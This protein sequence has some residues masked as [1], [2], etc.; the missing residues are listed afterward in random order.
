MNP[1]RDR[2]HRARE[3]RVS[4]ATVAAVRL[5][6]STR[7]G[8]GTNMHARVSASPH[9]ALFRPHVSPVR[10]GPAWGESLSQNKSQSKPT[11]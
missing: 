5:P 2:A 6:G 7:A 1:P 4:G 10:F 11:R 3:D 9:A 8:S